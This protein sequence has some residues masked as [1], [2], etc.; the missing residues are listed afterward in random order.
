MFTASS[1]SV[2]SG[3]STRGS[4]SCASVLTIPSTSKVDRISRGQRLTKLSRSF[5]RGNVAGAR[6]LQTRNHTK[7]ERVK[8]EVIRTYL[9]RLGF[10]RT[11]QRSNEAL[12]LLRQ[13]IEIT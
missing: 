12:A 4:D 3:M 5:S 11:W 8:P 6:S 13:P 10:P 9:K 7:D 2:L 1:I